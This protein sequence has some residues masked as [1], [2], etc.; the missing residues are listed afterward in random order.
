MTQSLAFPSGADRCNIGTLFRFPFADVV[1]LGPFPIVFKKS[2]DK[3]LIDIARNGKATVELG[4]STQLPVRTANKNRF[5]IVVELSFSWCKSFSNK[6]QKKIRIAYLFQ[7]AN[8]RDT[9]TGLPKLIFIVTVLPE[10]AEIECRGLLE[11]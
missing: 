2:A 6:T 8:N 11:D 4:L 10:T 5:V 7:R 1:I 3:I 9:I